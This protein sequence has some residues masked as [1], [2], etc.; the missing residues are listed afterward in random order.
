VTTSTLSQHLRSPTRSS[1]TAT[2][3]PSQVQ[4]FPPLTSES[5]LATL[6]AA[7]SLPQR[8]KSLAL[9]ESCPLPAPGTSRSLTPRDSYP[10]PPL[11]LRSMWLLL[12]QLSPP[13]LILTSSVV[14]R[15]PLLV[16]VSTQTLLPQPLPSVT[17]LSAISS[18]LAPLKSSAKSLD[19]NKTPLTLSTLTP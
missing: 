15:S 6:S 19:S 9:L 10:L 18:L 1:P 8:L 17:I 2:S 13:Q 14:T 16:P 3:S 12:S 11:F 5:S 7:L 4:L